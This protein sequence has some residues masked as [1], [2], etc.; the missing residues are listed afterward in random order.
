MT[1]PARQFSPLEE[2]IIE[3]LDEPFRSRFL[4]AAYRLRERLVCDTTVKLVVRDGWRNPET[5][6]RL[7]RK[8]RRYD[9]K[10]IKWVDAKDPLNPVVTNAAPGMSAHEYRRACHLI[11]LDTTRDH[12]PWL[13]DRD[14]R[15]GMVGEAAM[16]VS[17]LVWGGDWKMR[18]MAHVEDA[19]W[20]KLAQ[21]RGWVGLGPKERSA[22]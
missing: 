10:L 22:G 16:T 3:E 2:K 18:D 17:G 13:A 19:D 14:K 6:E 21:S 5:Q 12:N 9:E 20:K 8:G 7:Y 15:W 4:L 1:N 11:L